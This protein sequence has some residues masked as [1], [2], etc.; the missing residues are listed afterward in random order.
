MAHVRIMGFG[1]LPACCSVRLQHCMWGCQLALPQPVRYEREDGVWS[2]IWAWPMDALMTMVNGV[3]N[4]WV[5]AYGSPN[6]PSCSSP[7]GLLQA[8]LFMPVGD[9]HCRGKTRGRNEVLDQVYIGIF[10]LLQLNGRAEFAIDF[11]K[12]LSTV[13]LQPQQQQPG[14]S[15]PKDIIGRLS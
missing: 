10:L 13:Q 12:S 14:S 3:L 7:A 6:W 4:S 5:A 15:S 1:Q 2:G 9:C 8:N 11:V